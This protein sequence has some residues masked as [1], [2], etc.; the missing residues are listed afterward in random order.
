MLAYP[1]SELAQSIPDRLAARSFER[2]LLLLSPLPSQI[3]ALI[4]RYV[5]LT[6][7]PT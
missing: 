7:P 5:V 4:M 1:H 3:W 2:V 6:P